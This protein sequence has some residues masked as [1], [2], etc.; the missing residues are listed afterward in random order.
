MQGQS[1][2]PVFNASRYL[3]LKKTISP[4]MPRRQLVQQK[5]KRW[6][7]SGKANKKKVKLRTVIK[8]LEKNFKLESILKDVV[9]ENTR[10]KRR[11]AVIQSIISTQKYIDNL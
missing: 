10:L 6:K 3:R 11:L 4:T 7:R 5:K 8:L 9:A 2:S 1:L